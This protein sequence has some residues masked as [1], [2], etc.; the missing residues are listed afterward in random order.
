MRNN[1]KKIMEPFILPE[2]KLNELA[3]KVSAGLF[4]RHYFEQDQIQGDDLKSFAD[5]EQVNRFL[6][7]QI[8]QVWEMQLNKLYH[9]YFN[10]EKTE[11]KQTLQT[12]KNQISRCIE[13]SKGDFQPMLKRAV[14]NTL[15]L[16]LSPK[17]T[18]ESFFFAQQETVS[19]HIYERYAQF[20][21]DLDFVVDIILKYYQKNELEQIEKEG[22]FEKMDKVVEAYNRKSGQ[23]FDSYRKEQ[24]RALTGQSLDAV[25]QEAQAEVEA[26]EAQQ[27]QSEEAARRQAEAE[28]NRK[29]EEAKRQA[30]IE[31]RRQAEESQRQAEAEARRRAEEEKK[32]VSFFDT[33]TAN[34]NSSFDLDLDELDAPATSQP[35]TPPQAK[36]EPEPMPPTPPAQPVTEQRHEPAPEPKPEPPV[37]P[38]P[39]P[40]AESTPTPPTNQQAPEPPAR[41]E[42]PTSHPEQTAP[43]AVKPI[44]LS[45]T[46]ATPTPLANN[47]ESTSD[48]LDRFLSERQK[49]EAER[50]ST[51]ESKPEQPTPQPPASNQLPGNDLEEKQEKEGQEEKPSSVLDRLN[52]RSRTVADRFTKPKPQIADT[53]NGNR[54]IK[55]DEIPIHKQYQYV[56][57]V[58]EGNN[59][60]FRII[61]DKVNNAQNKDEV[62]DILGKFVLNNDNLDR[63]DYVVNEFIELLRNRY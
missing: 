55:L 12:L 7:F 39:E 15:K 22:F 26:R 47:R 20:F 44:P 36:K 18:F 49:L 34:K 1:R 48:F 8:F 45:E 59:V 43:P 33:L 46:P 30:E 2:E 40:M 63:N 28:A 11:I 42:P 35:E 54:K 31:A 37:E 53:I 3:Q 13:V 6:I 50:E 16:L 41:E 62:E 57:K 60:R 24:F 25:M 56:Q 21:H 14:Y 5:H 9:P 61:V 10:L 38:T 23:D 17:E 51:V 32:R 27:R 19:I 4:E 58:F 52:E 29:A